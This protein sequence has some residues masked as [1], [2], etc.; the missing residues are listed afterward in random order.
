MDYSAKELGLNK[1]H[2]FIHQNL[3]KESPM[4]A[5]HFIKELNPVLGI[6][7]TIPNDESRG[8]ESLF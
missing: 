4:L 5:Q 1:I 8:Q 7:L 3:E 6:N 2:F